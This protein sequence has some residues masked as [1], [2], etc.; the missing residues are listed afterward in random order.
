LLGGPDDLQQVACRFPLSINDVEPVRRIFEGF[1][2]E[3]VEL[4]YGIQGGQAPAK[5]L[6]IS[7][8]NLGRVV[9]LI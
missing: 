6:L 8:V 4:T 7:N 1:D 5:E 9:R 3:P 2:L